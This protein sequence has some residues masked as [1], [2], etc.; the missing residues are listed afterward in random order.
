M[1][2]CYWGSGGAPFLSN[3]GVGQSSSGSK[4][5]KDEVRWVLTT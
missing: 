1:Q 2:W 5:T 4:V 3:L